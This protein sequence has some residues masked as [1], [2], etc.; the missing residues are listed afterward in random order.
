MPIM[1]LRRLGSDNVIHDYHID[2]FV[3]AF[4][5]IAS[6]YDV[7]VAEGFTGTRAEWV[8]SLRGGAQ[9]G[10]T[11]GEAVAGIALSD[12]AGGAVETWLGTTEDGG[13][14]T[15][16]IAK[17]NAAGLEGGGAVES[18][19]G[20]DGAVVLDAADVGAGPVASMIDSPDARTHPT[21]SKPLTDSILDV[22]DHAMTTQMWPWLV[23]LRLGGGSGVA[24]LWSS[25]HD[26]ANDGIYKATAATPLGPYSVVGKVYDDAVSGNQ[27][28]TPSAL[29][30]PETSLYHLYYH[31]NSVGPGDQSTILATSPDLTTFT[32]VGVIDPNW[33]SIMPGD[34]H[35]GYLR[36]FRIGAGWY[37]YA[38]WGGGS[39]NTTAFWRSHDG[40][41]W[42]S[43]PTLVAHASLW[44]AH[45]SS[46]T[47]DLQVD[48]ELSAV[49]AWRGRPWVI[50][51]ARTRDAVI[52]GTLG[53]SG[54]RLLAAP[55]ADDLCSFAAR[56]IDITPTLDQA[57]EGDQVT[58]IGN[59]FAWDGHVYLP[60]RAGS[61]AVSHKTHSFGL[62][63]VI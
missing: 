15:Y 27:T 63:E 52:A 24:L 38:G 5:S 34:G 31:N 42:Y 62:L 7:A 39:R 28:E 23:D 56:P 46:Y 26:T 35:N 43:A 25:D 9:P 4:E 8:E 50:A 40:I 21:L 45:L 60:Y 6:A 3:D 10:E 33:T 11:S 47:Y 36:P 1:G 44:L 55:L 19:N 17:L 61:S 58:F 16:A 53:G 57:W 18:V 48:W 51:P 32:R 13:P 41:T 12:G 54:M 22:A 30:V 37:G 20:Q 29:W 59:A 49:L 2:Q 14:T